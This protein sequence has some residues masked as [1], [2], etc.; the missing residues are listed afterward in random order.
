MRAADAAM[1]ACV[2]MIV[3]VL[4]GCASDPCTGRP[5]TCIALRVEGN[6]PNLDRIAVTVDQPV[7]KTQST[8]QMSI[9][10]PID[11]GLNLP[12]SVSGDVNI[13]VVGYTQDNPV[14]QGSGRATVVDHRGRATVSLGGGVDV[15]P[16]MAMVPAARAQTFTASEPVTWSVREANGGVID[17]DGVYV[18]PDAPGTYHVIAT[19]VRDPA[20]NGV[21]TVNATPLS[22]KLLA[23]NIGGFGNIDGYGTA[24]RF[25]NGIKIAYPYISDRDNHVIRRIDE[26]NNVRVTT[27]AGNG[28]AGYR[29]DN[30]TAAQFSSPGGIALDF[31]AR[32]LYIADHDNGKVRKLATD[33][34]QVTTLASGLVG[35]IDIELDNNSSSATRLLVADDKQHRIFEVA[36]P[37]G[38]V[39]PIA[40]SGTFGSTDNAN[41]LQASML[42]PDAI[43]FDGIGLNFLDQSSVRKVDLTSGGTA[44]VTT[45][46]Q[47]ASWHAVAS[48]LVGSYTA[49]YQL[50]DTNMTTLVAGKEGSTNGPID[51]MGAAALF[52]SIQDIDGWTPNPVWIADFGT[53]R[54]LDGST[55]T[56]IAGMAP[57][58]V[59]LVEGQGAKANL[60][61]VIGLASDGANKIYVVHGFGMGPSVSV[62]ALD[63]A[64]VTSIKGFSDQFFQA[65]TYYDGQLYLPSPQK[66]ILIKLDP[67]TGM[68][69]VVAGQTDM[70]GNQ[71]GVGTA[72][73]FRSPGYIVSDGKGTLYL[74]DVDNNIIR[75]FDVATATV[76]TLAGSGGAGANDGVGTAA[77]F[78]RPDGLALDGK[79]ALYVADRGNYVVR[80]IDLAT[81]TVTR[82]AGQFGQRGTTDGR[83][84]DQA[85]FEGPWGLACDGHSLFVS[86]LSA[87]LMSDVEPTVR[88]I[89]L[90]SGMVSHFVGQPG[91]KG[92]GLGQLPASL[93]GTNSPGGSPLPPLIAPSGD[94]LLGA[95]GAVLIIQP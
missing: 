83:A 74:S 2:M 57:G 84:L 75:T 28:V 14:A 12:E 69:T 19:S 56:T 40:G 25:S 9:S 60:P 58:P 10:L 21:A 82:F 29:D 55:V 50:S 39:K 63:T 30:G 81:A 6:V 54:K 31:Q 62:I 17:A 73:R 24:A 42:G 80:K 49:V 33:T 89:D 66:Q 48:G 90:G 16:P 5:G 26:F 61:R 46:L 78:S 51:G 20:K 53:V 68:S 41:G 94:L 45:R 70:A 44:A 77:S 8:P 15:S 4:A 79:G 37:G 76:G 23:G 22:L 52:G 11:I 43:A 65:L 87:D 85:L 7:V 95:E 71:D 91:R 93:P 88:R 32:A 59:D 67:Q 3:A 1:R 18:A 47:Q 34:G 86:S 92:I 36:L 35:P 64:T 38:A 72:A 27:I 13:V